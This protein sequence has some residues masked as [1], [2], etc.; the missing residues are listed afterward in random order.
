MTD[1]TEPV[2]VRR[3]GCEAE[4]PGNPDPLFR[5]PGLR[6]VWLRAHDEAEA[7]FAAALARSTGRPAGGLWVAVGAAMVDGALR[8]AVEH[9]ALRAAEGARVGGEG[10]VEAVREALRTAVRGPRV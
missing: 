4:P 9:H 5:E 8:A 2:G 1:V 3:P 6:A 10:L 7:A